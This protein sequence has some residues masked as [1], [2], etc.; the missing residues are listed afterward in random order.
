MPP[1]WVRRVLRLLARLD[2]RSARLLLVRLVARLD[3]ERE[4]RTAILGLG[5]GLGLEDKRKEECY[6]YYYLLRKLFF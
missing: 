3:A 4:R 6:I 5:L 1:R 2:L